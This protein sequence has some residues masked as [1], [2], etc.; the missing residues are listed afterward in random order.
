MS[1]ENAVEL[2][3]LSGQDIKRLSELI[4]DDFPEFAAN[5]CEVIPQKKNQVEKP[6][7]SIPT[8]SVKNMPIYDPDAEISSLTLTIPSWV[9]SINRTKS[10]ADF[11]YITD[12]ARRKLEKELLELKKTIDSILAA[13][14]EGI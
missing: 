2:S 6:I 4:T 5:I 10:S 8:G 1:H 7:S 3:R 9:S 12:K 14:K 11:S 13:I